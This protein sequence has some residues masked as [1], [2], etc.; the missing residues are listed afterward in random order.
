MRKFAANYLIS[1]TGMFL[2]NGIV[3]AEANGT[4]VQ[5]IDTADDL[6]EIAGLI[7]H[8]GILIAGCNFLR[9]NSPIIISETSDPIRTLVL[10][11]VEEKNVFTVINLI[12]LGKKIQDQFPEMKIPGI[13]N[14]ISEILLSNGGFIKE[15]VHG[16]FLLIGVDLP[17]LR[18]KPTSKLKRIL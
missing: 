5:Y 12:D 2:K 17:Q 10:N 11:A 16:I 18:F 13:L 9:A 7:Y 15:Y 8:N 14:E 4:I 6:K 3:I 1:D